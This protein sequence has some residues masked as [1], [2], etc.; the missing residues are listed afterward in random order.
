ML[1]HFYRGF[2]NE[3]LAVA[4]L[5]RSNRIVAHGLAIGHAVVLGW[6]ARGRGGQELDIHWDFN[7]IIIITTIIFY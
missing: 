4:A 5:Q 3:E 2:L 6:L 1:A 7:D